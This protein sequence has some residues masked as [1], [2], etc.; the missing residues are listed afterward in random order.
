MQISVEVEGADELN[1]KLTKL[2]RL[3]KEQTAE[4]LN[5]TILDIQNRLIDNTT[6]QQAI[7]TGHLRD[8]WHI[9]PATK[10]NL[11]AKVG[12]TLVPHYAP[13]IEYGT[14]PHFP[15]PQALMPWVQRKLHVG[16]E[17]AASVA[18]LI[19]RKIARTGTKARPIFRPAVSYAAHLLAN[20]INRLAKKVES[21]L[22]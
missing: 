4:A 22:K 12:T 16:H 19:A 11:T 9:Q 6:K 7:D 18:H 14:K 21:S 2:P 20:E 1:E 17:R 5:R 10:T 15:P 13:D 8:S 3:T